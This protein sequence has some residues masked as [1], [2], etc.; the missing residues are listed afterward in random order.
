[1]LQPVEYIQRITDNYAKLGYK[2]Y[3][4]VRNVDRPP[5]QPLKKPLSQCRLGL[6]AS[7]G[8]YVTGQV[9]FHFKDDASFREI[10]TDVKTSDLRTAHFAYD[11]TDARRDPNVVFPI[12]TLRRLVKEGFIGSLTDHAFTFMGGIY[13]SRRVSEELAPRLVERLLA[14]K[15]DVALLVPV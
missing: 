9:A 10:P 8:I 2:P 5:W 1:M 11:Q 13:S 14:E 4:W 6:I 3:Q 12:D 7:G 15:A